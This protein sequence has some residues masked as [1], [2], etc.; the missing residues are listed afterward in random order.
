MPAARNPTGGRPA[1]GC[2]TTAMPRT[3]V[4]QAAMKTRLV[5]HLA[6][7]TRAPT[8]S[9][10][11]L[12]FKRIVSQQILNTTLAEFGGADAL[13]CAIEAARACEVTAHWTQA[14]EGRVKIAG[15]EFVEQMLAELEH[16]PRFC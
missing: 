6:A 7:S 10:E 12:L 2:G 5:V 9:E 1:V 13:A 3:T 8:T 14:Y 4:E 11:Y 15:R 16:D